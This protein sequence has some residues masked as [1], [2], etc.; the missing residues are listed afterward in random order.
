MC[1]RVYI[2]SSLRELLANFA[3]AAPGDAEG[4]ANSFPRYN[5]APQQD[6]PIIVREI[7]REPDV[8]G[9][10]FATARWGFIPAWAKDAGRPMINARS[11][12]I[13][14]N[15]MFKAAYKSKRCLVPINGFF[16]WK[17][18][19]STGKNKQP[20]AIAMKSGEPFALAGVWSGRRNLDTG[21]EEKMFAVITCAPNEMMAQIHDR[22]PVILHPEDYERWLSPEPDPYDLMRPFPSELMTMWPIGKNVGSP[23]NN[24]PDILD[25]ID[26]DQDPDPEPT[27][28]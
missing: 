21:L 13:S 27:L 20:Y 8:M 17:D 9:P 26:Q 2:R 6:Y 18:I 28:L 15:G 4:L 3:F 11:E 5:G 12:G 14:T 16:E 7:V 23:K 25:P 1:G 10:V 22:M 24:T 19:Y